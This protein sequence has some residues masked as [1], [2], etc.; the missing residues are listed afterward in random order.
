MVQSINLWGFF[1][2][3]ENIEATSF[4]HY[5]INSGT[6]GAV[7]VAS[8]SYARIRRSRVGIKYSTQL[9]SFVSTKSMPVGFA[10]V[11]NTQM[12]CRYMTKIV[13]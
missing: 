5:T 3:V 8:L 6:G 12:A 13:F 10:K 9:G 4:F 1:K 11:V 2:N 7:Q